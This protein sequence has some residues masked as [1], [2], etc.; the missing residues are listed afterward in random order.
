MEYYI[1]KVT[2][3]LNILTLKIPAT[4]SVRLDVSATTRYSESSIANAMRAPNITRKIVC[5]IAPQSCEYIRFW[6]ATT[7]S[8]PNNRESVNIILLLKSLTML[9]LLLIAI[10]T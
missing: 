6:Y 1:P 7:I 9:L 10:N 5:P 4:E 2:W 8:L 3:A